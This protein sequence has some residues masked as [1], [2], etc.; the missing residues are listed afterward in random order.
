LCKRLNHAKSTVNII[1]YDVYGANLA[2]H[3][4][5]LMALNL[6]RLVAKVADLLEQAEDLAALRDGPD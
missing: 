4:Q 2:L 5:H 1:H 6:L 3:C